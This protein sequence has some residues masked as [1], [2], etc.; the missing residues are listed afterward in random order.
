MIKKLYYLSIALLLIFNILSI[1]CA[2][3][4]N[5]SNAISLDKNLKMS[6]E[7]KIFVLN[8]TH[9]FG[10]IKQGKVVKHNY[11]I[12]NAGKEDLIISRVTPSCGCTA[13]IPK[14][15]ILKSSEETT[16][17]V[18]FDSTGRSGEQKKSIYVFSNDK[19]NPKIKL[20]FKVNIKK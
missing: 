12:K 8:A 13:A 14:K 2:K 3:D 11:I 9:D 4:S 18:D 10:I 19:K 20:S 5:N 1:S 15:N 7:A 6:K 17:E 16:I